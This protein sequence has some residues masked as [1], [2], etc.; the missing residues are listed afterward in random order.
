MAY[1]QVNG[2]NV[3]YE[4]HGTGKPLVLLHGGLLTIELAFGGLL[5]HLAK[6]R[7]VIAI[8]MQGHGRTADTDRVPSLELFASDVAGVL[9]TLGIERADV[10]G[11]SLGGLVGL[12]MA[13]TQPDRVDRLVA[14]AAHYRSQGYHNDILDP[15]LWSASRRMPTAE[16]FQKM[17]DAFT[18]VAPDPS[19]FDQVEAKL[20]PLVSGVDAWTEADFGGITAPTL[21]IIGD[22]DFVTIPH[23]ELMR[24]LIPGS[25]LAV[26]PGTTHMQ[27]PQRVDV[28]LALLGDFLQ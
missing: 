27:I 14:A 26:L 10:F 12:Q 28:L 23:A 15:A 6:S 13:L 24:D 4:V 20:Q 5:P 16:D 19:V 2:L 17:R 8:E 18:A 3:Y 21:L 25:Q 9:D 7:Q 11:Y 22:N 1:A